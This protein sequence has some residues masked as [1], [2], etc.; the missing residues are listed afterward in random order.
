MEFEIGRSRIAIEMQQ[1]TVF[2]FA[3][4]S[5]AQNVAAPLGIRQPGPAENPA[6]A[7]CNLKVAP[8]TSWSA[9]GVG[10]R[11][12]RPRQRQ[13][14][15]AAADDVVGA[16]LVVGAYDRYCQVTVY[17]SH[18]RSCQVYLA[19]CAKSRRQIR[20]QGWCRAAAADAYQVTPTVS[21]SKVP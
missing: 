21:E 2:W 9:A 17:L 6:D 5:N 19:V 1:H 4:M 11:R 14:E 15:Q 8:P 13:W 10:L 18:D 7:G 3:R 16:N 20:R 12:L